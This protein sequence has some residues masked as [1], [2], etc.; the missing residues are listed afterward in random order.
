MRPLLAIV[1]ALTLVAVAAAVGLFAGEHRPPGDA[2]SPAP[3]PTVSA[4]APAKA[5]VA[6]AAKA[7]AGRVLPLPDAI[8]ELELIKP[9]RS[10]RAEDFSLNTPGSGKVRLLD[11]R[12]QVV[13]IN[14]WATW[15][16]P[17]LEEM[18]AMERLYRQH[19]ELGFTL[20]AVSVDADSKLVA[21][22]VTAH[23]FTFPVAL[24]PS[25]SMANTY[26]VRALPS[27]FIVARDGTLAALAIGP[28][29]WDNDAAHSLIEGLA[30]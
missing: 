11:Y 21:P 22:F 27:T 29:H 17:C 13:L 5:T 7:R 1:I 9:A 2:A 23:K 26:G 10:K 12:G 18:P 19:R 24:D 6:P 3:A 30:R 28:R 4:S 15:C 8:R 25:M 20:V 16:P 14:F